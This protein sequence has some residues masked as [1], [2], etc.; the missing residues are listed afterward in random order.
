MP[1]KSV[2]TKDSC[3]LPDA[4]EKIFFLTH[5]ST[6]PY[7]Q[8][9]R[10]MMVASFIPIF[11][12]RSKNDLCYFHACFSFIYVCIMCIHGAHSGQK[13]SS[14]LKLEM[15]K[16]I[17]TMWMLGTELPSSQSSLQ[18]HKNNFIEVNFK[19]LPATL[20]SLID[21]VCIFFPVLLFHT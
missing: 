20:C 8:F 5:L 4:R 21:I 15:W 6:S 1:S 19:I 10:W 17:A 3:S 14:D 7:S 16:A 12:K 11:K 13:R 9:S 2:N 18:P